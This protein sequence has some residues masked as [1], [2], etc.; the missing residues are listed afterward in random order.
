MGCDASFATWPCGCDSKTTSAGR[1][2]LNEWHAGREG[3]E[4]KKSVGQGGGRAAQVTLTAKDKGECLKTRLCK[5]KRPSSYNPSV[6]ARPFA[7]WLD[8]Y[9]LVQIVSRGQKVSPLSEQLDWRAVDKEIFEKVS[10]SFGGVADWT[11]EV[12]GCRR[13]LVGMG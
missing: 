7:G 10:V 4:E 1:E 5:S 9:Y 8:R 3:K 13:S 6:V 11:S 12:S 2:V